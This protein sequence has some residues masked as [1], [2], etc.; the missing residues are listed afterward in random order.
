MSFLGST[1]LVNERHPYQL[2]FLRRLLASSSKLDT[3]TFSISLTH[4]SL[5]LRSGVL[6]EGAGAPSDSR[7]SDLPW[8]WMGDSKLDKSNNFCSFHRLLVSQQQLSTGFFI[9][10]QGSIRSHYKAYI[11]DSSGKLLMEATSQKDKIKNVCMANL[12]FTNFETYSLSER[13]NQETSHEEDQSGAEAQSSSPAQ[14]SD[15]P[16]LFTTLTGLHPSKIVP[17]VGSY[18]LVIHTKPSSL[19][20][21]IA[22][23]NLK[24]ICVPSPVPSAS[25]AAATVSSSECLQNINCITQ[26]D[27]NLVEMKQKLDNMKDEYI[28]VIF[29]FIFVYFS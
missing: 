5:L 14:I 1:I 13:V 7:I 2:S 4:Y 15:I 19:P 21:A 26:H 25:S 20:T 17:E 22:K 8:G 23:T 28:K 10:V 24:L 16:S 12:F 9:S 29:L 27:K 18:L 11:F 6:Q 3:D